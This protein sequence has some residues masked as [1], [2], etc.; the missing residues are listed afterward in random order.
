MVRTAPKARRIGR[1]VK[2]VPE[3]CYTL[4]LLHD[5]GKLIGFDRLTAIRT[6]TRHTLLFPRQ[7]LSAVLQDLHG[8]LGGLGAL[9]WNLEPSSAWAIAC[10]RRVDLTYRDEVM[11][12]VLAVAEWSDLTEIRDQPRDYEELWRRASLTLPLE[13]CREALDERSV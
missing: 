6:V 12:Q 11:S 5:L 9:A 4:G 7:F 3:T 2:L 10:H 13:Q 8:P 1:V